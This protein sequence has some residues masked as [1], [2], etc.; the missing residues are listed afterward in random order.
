MEA[1]CSIHLMTGFA[2]VGYSW[3]TPALWGSARR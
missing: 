3:I 2:E 1:L